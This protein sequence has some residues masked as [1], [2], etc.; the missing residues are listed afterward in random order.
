MKIT[1]CFL[2]TEKHMHRLMVFMENSELEQEVVPVNQVA[3]IGGKY[4][5]K[6]RTYKKGNN[7]HLMNTKIYYANSQK[8]DFA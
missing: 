6:R 4:Y 2:C 3:Q 7:L 8:S 1:M 5:R